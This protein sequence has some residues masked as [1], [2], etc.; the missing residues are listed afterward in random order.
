MVRE[1]TDIITTPF[2]LMFPDFAVGYGWDKQENKRFG[3][4]M[5]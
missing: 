5:E 2:L 3:K 4:K 1:N